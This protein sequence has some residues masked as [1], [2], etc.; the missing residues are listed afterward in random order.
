MFDNCLFTRGMEITS[1]NA[2]LFTTWVLKKLYNQCT[3]LKKAQWNKGT[4]KPPLFN[5]AGVC[6]YIY[7]IKFASKNQWREKA[8]L[9]GRIFLHQFHDSFDIDRKHRK[10]RLQSHGDKTHGIGSAKTMRYFHFTVLFFDSMPD[11]H[12][13]P[14][15]LAIF[16]FKSSAIFLARLCNVVALCFRFSNTALLTART[17]P[18][19]NR[20]EKII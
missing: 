10:I 8:A 14:E 2:Y 9:S 1:R 12:A 16:K 7:A 13:L 6:Q 15:D 18:A 20:A 5:E 11:F 3:W 4:D 19:L 17:F